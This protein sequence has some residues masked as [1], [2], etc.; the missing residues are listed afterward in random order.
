MAEKLLTLFIDDASLRLMVTR[1]QRVRKWAEAPLEPGMVQN[2]VVIKKAEVAAKIKQLLKAQ[3]VKTKKVILGL[4]GLH[5]LTR[6]VA[7]PPLP[8]AMLAE[9]VI[10]EA[11]SVLPVSPEQLYIS[12]QT[13]LTAE[14]KT[15][16]FMVAVPRKTADALVKTVQQAGL[17]VEFMDLK[18]LAL[19]RVASE[20]TAI[21]VDVQSTEFDIVIMA[22]GIPQPIRTVPFPAEAVSLPDKLPMI[23]KELDRTIKFY[24]S[25]NQEKP[26]DGSVAIF[27]SGELADEP[28][29]CQSLSDELGHPVLPLSSPL[30]CPESM[31]PGRYLVNIGLA[32]KELPLA[33]ET[34]L[35]VADLNVLPEVYRP[36]PISLTRVLALPS[37]ALFIGLLIP[38]VMFIQDT[39]VDIAVTRAK[40]DNTNQLTQQ[41]LSQREGLTADI[42]GL[43]AGLAEAESSQANFTVAMDSLE[44]QNSVINGDLGLAVSCL[45]AS[46]NLTSI[47]HASQTLTLN[48]SSPG[49]A[50]VLAYLSSLNNSGRFAEI[51]VSSIR[52]VNNGRMDFTLVLR[53]GGGE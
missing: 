34:G 39:S 17:K 9:A 29:P 47:T 35:C 49:E 50:E 3:R 10:R 7:L 48:G 38:L 2:N 15:E 36:K 21:I 33:R 18:P 53:T 12:W 37:A 43:E 46:A 22:E 44:K 14:D 1:G 28:E 19:A 31:P 51:I 20:E 26:L 32:L 6:P 41:R 13:T 42:A 4:S 25:N 52:R 24:N 5:C 40:I 11:R 8:K 16:V 30:G 23:K 45:P 27:V